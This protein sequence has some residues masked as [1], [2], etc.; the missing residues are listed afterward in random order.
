MTR[1]RRP[2]RVRH[3]FPIG[4]KVTACNKPVDGPEAEGMKTTV[5]WRDVTCKLCRKWQSVYEAGGK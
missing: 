3:Y 1:R 4:W 5:F 2:G